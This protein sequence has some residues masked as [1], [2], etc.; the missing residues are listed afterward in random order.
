MDFHALLSVLI[1][2]V[3]A[4]AA[5]ILMHRSR[6]D[7]QSS[8]SSKKGKQ[9]Q[10]QQQQQDVSKSR[11][12]SFEAPESFHFTSI[13]TVSSV[14]RRKYG[15]P[16]Q[17]SVIPTARGVFTLHPSVPKE[18]LEGLES[19]SHVWILF[20]FHANHGP[21]T[22]P[23]PG[24]VPRFRPRVE[25]PRLGGKK[26]GVFGTR[27]PHRVNPLGMSV[28]KL[29]QVDLK[30]GQLHLSGLDII[31]NTPV[32]DIK[33]YH[34]A[35]CFPQASQPEWMDARE[36]YPFSVDFSEEVMSQ[37]NELVEGKKLRFY[38]TLEEIVA[39]IRESAS[40]D[41][42]PVYLRKRS[43][44]EEIY[45]Y[46]LDRLNVQHTIDEEAKKVMIQAVFLYPNDGRGK[47]VGNQL[48][49]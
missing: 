23:T 26:V 21:S 24:S 12:A 11:G 30:R 18:S 6:R 40:L 4:A 22:T 14:F 44:K 45:G 38:T 20:I 48:Q 25:P 10:Q 19:Y 33:P 9:Q 35:D 17:G 28:V 7:R 32:V 13:G 34:P 46:D 31:D 8:S 36:A 47:I 37:L 43:S 15:A 1:A 39:A 29:E 5:Y 42:R 27:T 49:E 16:R 41:P 2:A 3:V